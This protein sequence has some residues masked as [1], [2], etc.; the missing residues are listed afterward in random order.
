MS[1][2]WENRKTREKYV[3]LDTRIYRIFIFALKHGRKN[4]SSG[5]NEGIDFLSEFI[6]RVHLLMR[7]RFRW[8][9]GRRRCIP[10]PRPLYV[11]SL[12]LDW[13]NWLHLG[14]G[15]VQYA[16]YFIVDRF[17]NRFRF[18]SGPRLSIWCWSPRG[19]PPLLYSSSHIV[20]SLNVYVMAPDTINRMY[21]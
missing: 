10:I 4:R 2:S 11:V 19:G 18:L 7:F 17:P 21:K 9:I 6:Q 13:I 3:M 1:G 20:L 8:N 14:I 5:Q 12:Y 16:Y 15:L